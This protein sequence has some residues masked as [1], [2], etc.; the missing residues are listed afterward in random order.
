M[1]NLSGQQIRVA[2]PGINL[3]RTTYSDG[4]VQTKKVLVK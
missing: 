4:S 2:Q 1:Y 3:I